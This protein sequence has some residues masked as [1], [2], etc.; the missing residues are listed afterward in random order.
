M[1]RAGRYEGEFIPPPQLENLHTRLQTV[2]KQ[3]PQ[4]ER[5][6]EFEECK[7]QL[8]AYLVASE[9]KLQQWSVKY[10]LQES[11]EAMLADYQ[12]NYQGR[13]SRIFRKGVQM[14]KGES[15]FINFICFLKTR[16]KEMIFTQRGGRGVLSEPSENLLDL[17]MVILEE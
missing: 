17:P 12:V 7:Y 11:V 2:C 5:R 15:C 1:K 4:R 3:A 10:G 16:E 6:L 9:S 13:R 14:Y 8:L